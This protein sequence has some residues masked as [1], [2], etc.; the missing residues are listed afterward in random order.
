MKK[1]NTLITG[2]RTLLAGQ[3]FPLIVAVLAI[4]ITLPTLIVDLQLDDYIIRSKLVEEV[5]EPKEDASLFG[6]FT[7]VSGTPENKKRMLDNGVMSWW[8]FDTM[9]ISF[10]RPLTELTHW[11]DFKLFANHVWVMHLENVLWYGLVVFVLALLFRKIMGAGWVAGFAVLLFAIDNAHAMP[12]AWICNRNVLIASF[13]GGLCL[14]SHHRWRS[15]KQWYSVFPA[16]LFLLLSLLAAEAGVAF[17]AYLF[18]YALFIDKG[19]IKNKIVSL[20]PYVPIALCWFLYRSINEFGAAQAGIYVDPS[21]DPLLFLLLM[22]EKIPI[23]IFTQLIELDGSLFMILPSSTAL[24]FW[25][26][27]AVVSLVI[28]IIMIPVLKKDPLARFWGLAMVLSII[29][30]SA[31]MPANRNLFI[32]SIGAMGLIGRYV[33]LVTDPDTRLY[34]GRSGTISAK[35]L[36]RILIILHLISAPISLIINPFIFKNMMNKM[37]TNYICALPKAADIKDKTIIIINPPEGN[38]LFYARY[39]L[40]AK[41]YPLPKSCRSLSAQAR[42]LTITRLDA[43]TIEVEITGFPGHFVEHIDNVGM[44]TI[45]SRATPGQIQTM[46]DLTVEVI[47]VN[48]KSLPSKARFTFDVPLEDESILFMRWDAPDFALYN[49]PVIGE[50][51]TIGE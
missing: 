12:V 43:K 6:L 10:F 4:I 47:E 22:L 37:Y 49:P 36:L 25:I 15:E 29:P 21:S 38:A 19:S 17:G 14:L 41:D 30:V 18:S 16:L 7:F 1:A 5:S 45:G 3:F 44:H 8:N 31:T 11:L 46:Q 35:V 48:E 9:K 20:L 13:F 42:P 27:M 32:I 50:T 2:G 51:D 33:A 39:I 23:Y 24:I 34:A 26:G 40:Q 28:I